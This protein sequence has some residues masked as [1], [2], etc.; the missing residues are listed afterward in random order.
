MSQIATPRH[1]EA[2]TKI[3]TEIILLA[4]QLEALGLGA[5]EVMQH[6]VK[7][8]NLD[9]AAQAGISSLDYLGS[10]FQR[11]TEGFIKATADLLGE[12]PA[13]GE[14]PVDFF[15]R[16]YPMGAEGWLAMAKKNGVTLKP[17]K[18]GGING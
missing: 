1:L 5:L 14:S 9:G 3:A 7:E 6:N 13:P 10:E 8:G 11:L 15:G 18:E 17:D 4:P 12:H 16:I 2:F